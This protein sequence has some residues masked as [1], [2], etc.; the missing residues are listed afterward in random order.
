MANSKIANKPALGRPAARPSAPPARPA[1]QAPAAPA[2]QA[3]K[4]PTRRVVE[5]PPV[6]K[7]ELPTEP[8]QMLATCTKVTGGGLSAVQLSK[9]EEH[10][11]VGTMYM[12]AEYGIQPGEKVWV[13][14][15]LLHPE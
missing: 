2:P 8:V 12:P 1:T 7:A 9:D 15:T 5:A 3:A 13:I 6:P 11:I 4:P 14:V 10:P